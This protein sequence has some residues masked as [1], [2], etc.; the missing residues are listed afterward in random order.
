MS[1]TR[2]VHRAG[3]EA[4]EAPPLDRRVD[5]RSFLERMGLLTAAAAGMAT[6][7]APGAAVRT[8]P[9]LSAAGL[10]DPRA[11]QETEPWAMSVGE[12]ASLIR[13]GELSPRELVD[14]YLRR[15][16]AMDAG[17]LAFNT[18]TADRARRDASRAEGLSWSGPLHGIPLAIKDNYYTAGVPTTANSHIFADFVPDFDATTWARL[19]DAGAVLLGKTQMGPLATSRATTPDGANTTV[20]A[21]SARDASVSPGGSSSGSATAV[22]AGLAASSTGTQTG[23]SITNPSESQGLT[24][25]KPTMGRASLYG[26]I[27]L[28]YT[29][30]HPGPLARDAHDAALM[31]QAMA[32]PDPADPR[33][34][35]NPPVPDLVRA[36][37][38]VRSGSATRLRWPTNVGVIP[39]YLEA[40]TEPPSFDPDQA[41]DDPAA[42]ERLRVFR[43][44]S[45]A[46]V[47]AR[48][49]MLE[50]LEAMGAR[51]VEVELP[52]DW[53]T[54]TSFD[55]NN[56][57]LP[58]RTEPFLHH[59]RDDVRKFG[60][61][62]S[63]WI[64][65]LL[66]SGPEYLRGQRAKMLLL[67]RVLDDVF[68]HC[69]V[70]VQT[71]PVPFDIIGLPLITFP[72]GVDRSRG[73]DLPVGALFGGMPWGEERLL[74]LAAAWQAETD[75]HRRRPAL[76]AD[77]PEGPDDFGSDADVD[78]GR[79]D[80]LDVFQYGQ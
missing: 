14:E 6:L 51:V 33:T 71:S 4:V 67:Q 62:L 5:R 11:V 37:T 18:V 64:N 43:E 45:R 26:I 52:A 9:R 46:E 55:F 31:L 75:W 29:R 16:E 17:L 36:A 72:V 61:S 24:G 78:R 42:Q 58:E 57:R 20:N 40:A 8:T 74:A 65:G 41:Q 22:A 13:A 34:L 63:P 59:L 10:P 68:G 32:G 44:R 60:V 19:K 7:P 15:I 70:V 2:E 73:F 56:V 12:L 1:R 48:R 69:D 50:G 54:L 47:E 23:G 35:G 80:V 39:G 79:T 49:A 27:P 77:T 38:P 28:T 53:E 21:W 76:P 3:T 66:L 30:D 25:L